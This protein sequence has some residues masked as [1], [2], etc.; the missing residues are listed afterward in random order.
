M[1][2][3]PEGEVVMN[4]VTALAGEVDFTR[5]KFLVVDS[6]PLFRDMAHTALANLRAGEIKHAM[7]AHEAVAILKQAGQQIGGLICDWELASLGGL[8]VLRMIRTGMIVRANPEMCAV[9]L[10][11]RADAAAM[12]AAMQLDVNGIAIAPL[13]MEKLVKTLTQAMGRRWTL[14]SKE[15]YL[16][17][18]VIEAPATEAANGSGG[19]KEIWRRDVGAQD[20]VRPRTIESPAPKPF[21]PPVEART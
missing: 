17:V 14:Q 20:G 16:K 13:S 19:G 11:G 10:T 18:P 3:N 4:A 9:L 1:A 2:N 12:R 21:S 15:H 8:E 5:T 7:D 6:K